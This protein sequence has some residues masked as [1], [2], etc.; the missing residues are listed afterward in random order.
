M[1]VAMV[2][3]ARS[4]L[5]LEL[6]RR[7]LREGWSV[8]VLVRATMPDDPGLTEAKRDGRL[9]VYSGD[10][11]DAASRADV[12]ARLSAGEPQI[13]V[14]FNNAGVSTS[15]MTYSPQGRELNFEV[16]AIAPYVVTQGLLPNL[17]AGG[18][19]KVINTSSSA[20]H[21]AKNYDPDLLAKPSVPF[22]KLF[23]PY[24]HSKLA[25]SLWTKAI[26][27]DLSRRGVTIISVDPGANRTPMTGGTG[28]PAPLLLLAK[29]FF[30]SP[31]HGAGL[32]LDGALG[33]HSAGD[34]VTKGTAKELPFLAEADKT[35]ALVAAASR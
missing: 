11:A 7:L 28:M 20:V 23:G 5:G 4:G 26:A 17:A 10:L 27:P 15:E 19:G 13:D 32:L 2:T 1:K 29:L 31:A 33:S 22:K 9:R 14:L 25:L 35:L 16:N 12:V 34:F 3:G 6:T 24:A 21:Y 18:A 8:A 30:K